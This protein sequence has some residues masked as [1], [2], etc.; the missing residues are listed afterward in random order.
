MVSYQIAWDTGAPRDSS[1][2]TWIRWRGFRQ[3]RVAPAPGPQ[4]FPSA[5]ALNPGQGIER[6]GCTLQARHNASAGGQ[7]TPAVPDEAE[8]S[9]TGG[10]SG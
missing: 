8:A 9:L 10:D 6:C 4:G 5:R 1:Q 2:I 3:C 7:L